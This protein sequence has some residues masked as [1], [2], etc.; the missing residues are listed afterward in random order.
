[1]LVRD[2]NL[3]A[4]RQDERRIEVI[5]NGPP[6]WG[7]SQ[8]AVDTTLV[9]PLTSAGAPRRRSGATAGAALAEVRRSKERTYPEFE[10]ASRCRLVVLGIEVGG[11]WSAETANFV[12]LLARA[13]ARTA[14][15][16]QRATTIA[17]ICWAMVGIVVG[18]R[19]QVLCCQLAFLADLQYRQC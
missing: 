11:R 15:P 4:A 5:A 18:C 2:L 8:L 17:A 14:L 6:L 7:G 9:S 12:R 13:R 3:Q 10:R 19:S 16:L 1:M